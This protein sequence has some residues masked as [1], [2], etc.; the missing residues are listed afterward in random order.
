MP[1][2]INTFLSKG[3]VYGGA[4][5]CNFNVFVTP[6][7]NIGI[8]AASVQKFTFACS[9][10]E[11]PPMV[12]NPIEVPYFGRT[13]KV[14]GQQHFANWTVQVQNDEDFAVRAMFELWSNGINRLEANVRDP[15]LIDENYKATLTVN[16]YA[17]DGSIIRAYTIVDA[18][19]MT[20]GPIALDWAA[21]NSIEVF[22]VEFAYDYWLPAV[23]VAPNYN[24]GGVNQY[25][26]QTDVDGPQGP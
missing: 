5:N 26:D 18:W 25:G 14:A 10:A 8:D 22:P 19:P 13:V 6:P 20:I 9:G 7:A 11:L 15:A 2:N 1:F 21:G 24:A 23:E 3:L 4:R 16:Q 12:I 17:K